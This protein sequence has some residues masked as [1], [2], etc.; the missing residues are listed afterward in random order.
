M[1]IE[2]EVVPTESRPVGSGGPTRGGRA[3]FP[4]GHVLSL[5]RVDGLDSG[6]IDWGLTI[7]AGKA[8]CLAY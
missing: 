3:V 6:G 4:G 1:A 2:R 7:S 8:S 5:L